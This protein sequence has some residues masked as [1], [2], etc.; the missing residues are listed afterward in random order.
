MSLELGQRVVVNGLYSGVVRF[1]GEVGYAKGQFVGVELDE[2]KGKNDGEVKG[3]RY[4]SCTRNHGLL[5]RP[6]DVEPVGA[7][8]L[9]AAPS[10]ADGGDGVGNG[11]DDDDG[12]DDV[13]DDDD[14]PAL[15]QA[16]GFHQAQA[17][18]AAVAVAAVGGG[19]GHSH[20]GQ[21]CHGH[22]HS[23]GASTGAGAGAGAAA[24]HAYVQPGSPAKQS[25]EAVRKMG[26]DY[27]ALK[28]YKAALGCYNRSVVLDD[29]ASRHLSLG[30]RAITKINLKDYA[31]AVADCDAALALCPDYVKC[32]VRK[33][34]AYVTHA[35]TSSCVLSS[36]LCVRG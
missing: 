2:P 6:Y 36:Q 28:E 20:G 26:N 32:H 17:H 4:F 24:S 7:V 34:M 3:V 35:C 19:H 13:D 5:A 9:P 21:P 23:H 11:N 29:D 16:T 33:G 14:A 12:D 10:G 30:N 18:Q 1:I 8:G 25:A 15:P 22:G 27:F 31:G